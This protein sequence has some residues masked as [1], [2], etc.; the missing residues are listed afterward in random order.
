MAV[1]R[2]AVSAGEFLVHGAP[3]GSAKEKLVPNREF[4]GGWTRM[5]FGA[6]KR[7]LLRMI[8]RL[9]PE[10]TGPMLADEL[11]LN[12]LDSYPALVLVSNE[13]LQR[14]MDLSRQDWFPQEHV[15]AL[16]RLTKPELQRIL[17]QEPWRNRKNLTLEQLR[18]EFGNRLGAALYAKTLFLL[19][20]GM[21]HD[22]RNGVYLNSRHWKFSAPA[23]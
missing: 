10:N 20:R 4:H 11:H 9:L 15:A 7:E 21:R 3:F 12:R 17:R 8:K 18:M 23:R 14:G 22:P 13:R 2:N 19:S 16:V 5:P 6:N 1:K